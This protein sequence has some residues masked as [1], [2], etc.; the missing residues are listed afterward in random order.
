MENEL[1]ASLKQA[2][3]SQNKTLELIGLSKA[4]FQ[5]RAKPR[6]RVANP[7]PH[8]DR[9]HPAALTAVED[10]KIVQLLRC[11]KVSVAETFYR[12]LDGGDYIASMSSFHRRAR[13]EKIPMAATGRRRRRKAKD[14]APAPIPVLSATGPGQVVCWDISFL[15]GPYRSASYALYLIID[16]FS[17]LIVGWSI[18]ERE[19]K[20]IAARLMDQVLTAAGSVLTV[21]SDNGGAMTSTTMC[22]ILDK[23]DAAQSLIRPGVSNDNAQIESLFRTVKYGPT[24][25]GAFTDIEH[26]NTWF[27]QFVEAYNTQ[28][29]HTGLA[30][31]TPAQVH[32][33]TWQHVAHRRQATL[34]AAFLANPG[35]YRGRPN[36]STPPDRVSLNL[37]HDDGKTHTPPTVLEL[38]AG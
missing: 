3:F 25:P 17:R 1:I 28:H 11:S 27:A 38:L 35:R 10:E 32:D 6:P 18:Q 4:S 22:K 14:A 31:F 24:W 29:H 15:P 7:I 21:H 33:G 5:Y 2:G 26:A 30:G 19:N 13:R 20:L 37:G 12:H 36:V 16:L 34:D 23:H 8:R 9:P